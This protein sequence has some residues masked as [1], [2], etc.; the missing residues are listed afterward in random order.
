MKI[1]IS[2]DHAAV[3]FKKNLSVFIKEEFPDAVVTTM[4]SMGESGDYPTFALEAVLTVKAGEND[5]G[6]LLCG[7]GAGMCMTANK[8][9]GIRAV[10]CSE[11]YTARLARQHNNA[12]ILCLGA[13]VVGE[14]LAKD[15][16]K[17]FIN[18]KFEGGRHQKRIE[19][20]E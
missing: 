7:S 12:Q 1:V 10:V 8:I 6:I 15:I 4:G 19:M 5:L 16:V 9:E 18:A 17:A 2:N 11:P 14:E 13:R 3:E 20:M